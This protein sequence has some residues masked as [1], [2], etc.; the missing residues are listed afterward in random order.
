MKQILVI[1]AAV[2][3][4]VSAS[5]TV[6]STASGNAVISSAIIVGK[7]S[8]AKL[9]NTTQP[10]ILVLR[11]GDELLE[12]VT[13]CAKDAKLAS[14]AINGLGQ[15]HNPSL[16]YFSKNPKDK[17]VLT[18][19]SGYYELASLNGDITN[20]NNKYYTHAHVVLADEKFHGIA[21]HLNSAIVGLTVEIAII[22]LQF[23]VQRAVDAKTGF[24]LIVQ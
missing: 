2:I 13:Q 3:G 24:G 16:A 6:A 10:F 22:P 12:S 18:T 11:S 23:P 17:P 4:I 9:V 15:L 1:L 19:F 20:N 21:G 5:T 7:S 8:C 14:A